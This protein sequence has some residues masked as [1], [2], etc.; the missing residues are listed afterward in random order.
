[1]KNFLLELK[2]GVIF[3]LKSLRANKMRTA[4]TTLGIVIGIVAVTTM[5][6]AITGLRNSFLES[7]SV[8]GTD[9]LYVEK[10]EW[11]GDQD[12][13]YYRNRKDITWEQ[14][15]KLKSQL[16]LAGAVV[17]TV[18]S[19]G[20]IVKRNEKSATSTSNFG[21]TEDYIKVAGTFPA[22]GRFFTELEV[23]GA[24]NVCVIGQDI[25]DKLF[26]NEDPL[27]KFIKMKGA[28]LKVIG[29]LEKQ[30]SGFLGAA[31]AD[32]Q[33]IL[34][35][36]LF[37]KLFGERRNSF[38]IAIKAINP[39][40]LMDAKEEVRA[41]MRTIRKVPPHKPDDFAINQMEAFTKA[42]DMI[43]G[44]IAIAG[45]VITALSLFVGAI[46]IM[47]IMFVSVKER[48]KEI[49]IRKAIGAKTWSIL[50]QFLAE[51]AIICILG[52]I[53]GLIIAFPVSLIVNQFIPTSMP[54]EIIV[55]ALVISALVGVASG[56]LPAFK[57]AKMNPV[58][59]LRFE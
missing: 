54:L 43:I 33:V 29:V 6:T 34:P 32:G 39:S 31:S 30:G 19:H 47:N 2:E 44:T 17:P 51:A 3:S 46:G 53:I 37:K 14:Y 55:L 1:M 15:E 10:F 42:Y 8:I 35:F 56:F 58:E 27:N 38:R 49:G 40:Q 22:S 48:T 59:A 12:W 45:L 11:F 41:V 20:E 26:A 52:G 9:V 5:Q 21:T 50:I 24:R 4:L 28:P 13:H 36:Q 7:I 18:R 25:A 16:K 57:A 23:K